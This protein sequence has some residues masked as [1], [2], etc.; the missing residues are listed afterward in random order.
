MT[1]WNEG[2]EDYEAR[3]RETT[4]WILGFMEAECSLLPECVD[5]ADRSN[6]AN[7]ILNAL[8]QSAADARAE[9][10]KIAEQQ[11]REFLSPEYAAGQPL[12]SL[13]ERFACS[14][15]AAAIRARMG[16]LTQ[17]DNA[18]T[19]TRDLR[20]QNVE[21]VAALEEARGWVQDEVEADPRRRGADVLARIDAALAA[22]GQPQGSG[23]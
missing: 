19:I 16:V 3:A 8:A 14:Q 9:C 6:I 12:S 2:G 7:A 5:W 1:T 15:V 17:I 21:L 23:K 4:D 22:A 10:V 13:S 11:E 18:T 20:A